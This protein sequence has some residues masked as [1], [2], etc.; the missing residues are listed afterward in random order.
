MNCEICEQIKNRKGLIYEDQD[1]A[2]MLAQKPTAVGH[3]YIVPKKHIP[4][5]EQVSDP[6]I[7][8]MFAKANK[9]S[10]SCFESI[11]VQGTNLL[12][13]NGLPAGQHHNHCILHVI[14]RKEGDGLNLAW[15]PKQLTEE[16]MSTA[17]IQ[18][19]EN[20]GQV[21]IFEK[22]KEKPAEIEKPEEIQEEEEDYRIKELERLP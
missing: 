2:A 21:G 1:I 19:K 11:G 7:G 15:Q 14:P 9:I 6:I 17:E 22:E 8:R 12:I 4:I 10:M 3:V 18:I 13:Q 20:T 5:L 16:E